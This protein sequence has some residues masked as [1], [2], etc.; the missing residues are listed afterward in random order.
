ML[1]VLA[2]CIWM[3]FATYYIIEG[4]QLYYQSAL[5]KGTVDIHTIFEVVKNTSQYSGIKA[6]LSTKGIII[7][8]NKWDDIYISP[9]DADQFISELK[10]I[11]PEIKISG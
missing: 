10:A 7:K 3:W 8:F 9:S 11:N 1:A 2:Y 4:K 6:S 5:F